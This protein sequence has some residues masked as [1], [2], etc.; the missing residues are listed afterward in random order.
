MTPDL[1]PGGPMYYPGKAVGGP[2]HPPPGVPAVSSSPWTLPSS[3]GKPPPKPYNWCPAGFVDEQHPIIQ[4]M[5]EPLL[6]KFWGQCLVSNILT[7]SRKRFD[8]LP[9]LKAYPNGICWLQSIAMCP[10][11]AQCAFAA[12]HIPKGTLTDAQADGVVAALQA[13]VRAMVNRPGAPS[14]TGK[15][16][17]RGGR[18]GGGNV[19]SGATPATP[20]A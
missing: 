14:P 19:P 20:P 11:G 13:G 4:A 7:A 18:G 8:S 9:R 6:T 1:Q 5:M 15:C 3:V 12:G 10:Y 2:Y 16:K 17:L